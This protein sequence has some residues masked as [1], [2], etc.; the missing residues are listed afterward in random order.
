MT[1]AQEKAAKEAAKAKRS[2]KFVYEPVLLDRFDGRTG[3]AAGDIVVKIQPHG[4]P[5]NGTMGQCYVGD[6]ESGAFIGMVCVNSLR[7]ASR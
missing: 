5:R 6:P 1:Y 2:Q 3:L 7:K 4:C